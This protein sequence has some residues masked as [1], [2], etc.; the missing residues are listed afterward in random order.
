MLAHTSVRHT[1]PM[2]QYWQLLQDFTLSVSWF[3]Y[4]IVMLYCH[5]ETGLILIGVVVAAIFKCYQRQCHQTLLPVWEINLCM[6]S[7]LNK[8]DTD[9]LTILVFEHVPMPFRQRVYYVQYCY[10][11]LNQA[12]KLLMLLKSYWHTMGQCRHRFQSKGILG[13]LSVR[14]LD[15]EMVEKPYVRMRTHWRHLLESVN[16]CIL[17]IVFY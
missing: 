17:L 3:M 8:L 1:L 12:T 11:Q 9:C 2:V 5:C 4:I 16:L 10:K 13:P 6:F 15:E 7:A 14:A